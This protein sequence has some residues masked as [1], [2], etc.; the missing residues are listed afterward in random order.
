M[1]FLWLKYFWNIKEDGRKNL[2]GRKENTERACGFHE[3]ITYADTS[4]LIICLSVFFQ[5]M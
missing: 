1:Y 3:N 5:L 2:L 4:L